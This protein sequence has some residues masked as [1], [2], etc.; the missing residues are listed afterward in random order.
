M[1]KVFQIGITTSAKSKMK[2]VN[3]VKAFKNKGLENDRKNNITL[4]ESEKID[5]YNKVSRALI[6]YIDFRRNIITK[7]ISLNELLHR[8][9][10]IGNVKVKT[11]ELCQPCK[12]LQDELKQNLFVKRM[13]NKSGLRC[14]ILN[15]GEIFVGD[16]IIT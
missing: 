4:I 5:V 6:P 16:K 13:I 7:D 10:Y 15:D 11:L 12:R 2:N 1:S 3:S 8:E 9:F 14:V